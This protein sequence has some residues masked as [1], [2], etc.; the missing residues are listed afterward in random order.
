METKIVKKLSPITNFKDN[1]NDGL[2]SGSYQS[3]SG[4]ALW[5]F[6]DGNSLS[7]TSK[8][9]LG[10]TNNGILIQPSNVTVSA[11]TTF[12]AFTNTFTG[13]LNVSGTVTGNG[14]GLTGLNPVNLLGGYKVKSLFQTNYL[15]T[16]NDAILFCSGTNQVITLPSNAV[17]GFVLTIA[18]ASTNGSVIVTNVAN[19]VLGASSQI[20]YGP[21]RASFISDSTN[22]W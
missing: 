9:F 14:S 2:A 22:Y 7:G 19:T 6:G 4:S 1:V 13:S 18:V 16:T 3:N 11:S 12:T 20:I 17:A 8:I 10:F 21:A 5:D 15:A